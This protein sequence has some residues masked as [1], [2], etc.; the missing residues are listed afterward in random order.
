MAMTLEQAKQAGVL[1]AK[2]EGLTELI[3]GLQANIDNG[4]QMDHMQVVLVSGR[5][6]VAPVRIS[7]EDSVACFAAAKAGVEAVRAAA[8]AAFD[9]LVAAGE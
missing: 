6:A 9:A 4:D 3:A 1:A 7:V 2:I 5:T 8:Q